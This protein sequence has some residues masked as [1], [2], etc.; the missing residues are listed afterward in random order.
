MVKQIGRVEFLKNFLVGI[1]EVVL[2]FLKEA[3]FLC[4]ASFET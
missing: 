1:D 3:F 4:V 2:P